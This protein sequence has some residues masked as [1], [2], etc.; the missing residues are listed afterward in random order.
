MKKYGFSI[1][2]PVYNREDCLQKSIDSVSCQTYSN[3]EHI[4]INDGSTDLTQNIITLTQKGK[5][6]KIVTL[7]LDENKGPNCARN[8]GIQNAKKQ[9][10]VFLDSDDQ[11]IPE[12][13][14]IINNCISANPN[15]AT[16]LF[17]NSDKRNFAEK[18]EILRNNQYV[19]NFKDHLSERITL[20][21]DLVYIFKTE[22][23]K[24][25]PFEA[26]LRIY[27]STSYLQIFKETESQYYEKKEI[28]IRNRKR[29]D[30]VSV[31]NF[32][33]NLKYI[34]QAYKYYIFLIIHF[35]E[36]YKNLNLHKQFNKLI[37]RVLVL[38]KILKHSEISIPVYS[39]EYI[40][41]LSVFHKIT[42]NIPNILLKIIY[43]LWAQ[44]KY[45]FYRLNIKL[46]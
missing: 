30:A 8:L 20:S 24:K 45:Y 36:D 41:H 11:L 4:I 39:H 33:T 27:E 17:L 43:V 2:T 6:E 38:N 23:L 37:F 12:A 35:Y 5:K 13:L 14:E 3:Y 1:I 32:L 44:M 31:E 7:K 28:I 21:A 40:Y 10:V 29:K 9:Y 15:Y 19:L 26:N 25:Y 46:R 18:N 34:S 16:Y 22:L 42:L